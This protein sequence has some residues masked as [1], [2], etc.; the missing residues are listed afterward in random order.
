MVGGRAQY[1]GGVSGGRQGAVWRRSEWWEGGR[2]M[3]A[4]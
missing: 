3:A 1:G 4:E 2:S